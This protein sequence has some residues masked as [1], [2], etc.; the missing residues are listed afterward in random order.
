MST[1]RGSIKKTGRGRD[2]ESMPPGAKKELRTWDVAGLKDKTCM[3]LLGKRNRGKTTIMTD[4]LYHNQ[5]KF[6]TVVGF[7]ETEVMNGTLAQ[8][9]PF[10]YIYDELDEDVLA[11]IYL[12]QKTIYENTPDDVTNPKILMI[13][14]DCMGDKKFLNS[15]AFKDIFT[16]GRHFGMMLIVTVQHM[17][18]LPKCCRKN[19]DYVIC[20]QCFDDEVRADLYKM[21]F[22]VMKS[23]KLFEKAMD[24]YTPNFGLLIFDNTV[25]SGDYMDCVFKYRA[26]H[27][28]P[29]FQ[30]GSDEY[31]ALHEL[32]MK[33]KPKI[34]W[35]V[36]RRQLKE[37]MERLS[38]EYKRDLEMKTR[39]GR[40]SDDDDNIF[41]GGYDAYEPNLEPEVEECE[42]EVEEQEAEESYHHHNDEDMD[43]QR[44]EEQSECSGKKEKRKKGKRKVANVGLDD[45][46]DNN[47][48]Y[49]KY[50]FDVSHRKGVNKKQRT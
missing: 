19:T 14:D 20:T 37:D 12:R 29:D 32:G 5:N 35:D 13:F 31:W 21:G 9:M 42:D 36:F 49:D 50:G 2:D 23:Y 27:I 7:S 11:R 16:K 38:N 30:V 43:R 39:A 25:S 47:V 24:A 8:I 41:I 10:S 45:D 1:K 28:I 18:D 48:E 33:T 6:D 4:M 44:E 40:S 46:E 17:T 26:T 3:V 22:S 15:K 34:N